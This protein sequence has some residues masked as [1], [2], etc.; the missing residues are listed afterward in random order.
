[1][2]DDDDRL[3]LPKKPYL[4]F[5]RDQNPAPVPQTGQQAVRIRRDIVDSI[6][7]TF[8]QV[9]P[10]N[11]VAEV[12]GPYY[13]LQFQ[14]VAEELA[15][16]QLALEEVGLES[17]VNFARPEYLW[18]MIGTLVFPD[19]T[20]APVGIPE[21]DGDLTYREFLRRMI[22]LLLQ[23]ATLDVQ[24]QGLELLTQAVVDVIAKVNWSDREISAWGFGEQHEFEINVLGRTVFTDPTTGELIEGALGT[25]FPP[26]PFV[27]LRNNLRVLRAL[28]PG[29]AVF[30]YRHLFLDAFGDLFAGEPLIQLDSWY[31][32][33]FR[34]FC[35]GMKEI[36]GDEGVTLASRMLFSDVGREFASVCAG[37]TLEILDGP[38][39][40]PTSGG[41]D[42]ATLGFYRVV[43][44]RRLAADLERDDDGE[45][46]PDTQEYTTS[47]TGL[48]GTLTILNDDGDLEDT[49]QDF[50]NAVEGETLTILG[51]SNA[52]VYR[53]GTLLG[54]SGGP[55]GKV[56][57][58]SGVTGVRVAPSILQILTRMPQQAAG[59]SYRVSVERLG[60]REPFT[61]LE[62]DASAQ[63]YV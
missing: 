19:V 1:M 6:L 5:T 34:K 48:S 21:V 11:Y 7:R 20:K 32:E 31:Y 50:S 23:G 39:S 56:S 46:V 29:K 28:K 49:S 38:N 57:P 4:P 22:L 26:D 41:E 55:V 18:Q 59:Q 14:A 47:P 53:L 58:G 63:F 33:D 43:G 44:V 27:T 24:K 62:E 8:Q 25:G 15:R 52:G 35:C 61:V 3:V 37:A 40:K 16:V 12:P 51:G 13:V 45:V 17:D 36:T 42:F 30:E 54:N 9:L 2:S 60:V 10:S